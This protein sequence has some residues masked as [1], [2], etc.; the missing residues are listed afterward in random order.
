MTTGNTPPADTAGQNTSG[1]GSTAILPPELKAWNWGAFFLSWIWGIGNSTWIAFLSFIPVFNFIW[2]FFLG[3]KGNKWAW[4]NKKWESVEHFQRVQKKWA[5]WGLI[6]FIICLIPL[7]V[8]G[9]WNI[10]FPFMY[11]Y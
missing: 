9:A 5:F 10:F 2:A 8:F 7:I 6:I 1:M 3:A 4:Q 11:S